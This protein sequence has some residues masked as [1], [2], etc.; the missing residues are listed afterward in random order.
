MSVPHVLLTLASCGCR[1]TRIIIDGNRKDEYR[2]CSDHKRCVV[3]GV[4]TTYQR[5]DRASPMWYRSGYDY[6]CHKCYFKNHK[7]IPS[8][9]DRK[10]WRNRFGYGFVEAGGSGL[11]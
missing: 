3:C 5:K 8:E 7:T 9:K 2:T 11:T 10:R 1:H 6:L 4:T